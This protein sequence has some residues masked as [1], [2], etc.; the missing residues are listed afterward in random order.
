MADL[1]ISRTLTEPPDRVW[2]ALTDPE[3]LAAWFWPPSFAT[4]AVSELR[5]SG[6][7][8]IESRAMEMA[9][10]GEFLEIEPAHRLSHTWK[11]DGDEHESVVAYALSPSLDGTTL[12][13]THTG[14]VDEAD[15]DNHIQG[16]NDCLD[17][18]PAYLS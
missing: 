7:F 6:A 16:W 17:R 3:A 12:V 2:H 5:P 18:L 4:R 14:L 15:R 8:R 1:V 11:W 13:L 9:V 10:T